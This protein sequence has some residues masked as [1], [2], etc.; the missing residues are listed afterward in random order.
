MLGFASLYLYTQTAEGF[1]QRLAWETIAGA[2][3]EGEDVKVMRT[4]LGTRSSQ[5]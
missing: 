2:V 4:S 3:Y 1:Y 5:S